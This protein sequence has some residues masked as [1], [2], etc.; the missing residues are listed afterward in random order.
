MNVDFVVLR[1]D[2]VG[3]GA[4]GPLNLPAALPLWCHPEDCMTSHD[5]YWLRGQGPV[6]SACCD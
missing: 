1:G 6:R 2:D 3:A 5:L 4:V